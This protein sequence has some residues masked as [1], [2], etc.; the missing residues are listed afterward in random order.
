MVSAPLLEAREKPIDALDRPGS[1]DRD[2]GQVLFDSEGAEDVALLGCPAEAA[3]RAQVRRKSRDV[4]AAER[5]PATEKGGDADQRIDKRC[6][7]DAVASE[8]R[9]GLAALEDE[10]DAVDDPR[11]AIACA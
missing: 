8:Q 3:P 2:R 1:R 9:Q 10:A 4:L 11:L 7:A 5:D 6:L